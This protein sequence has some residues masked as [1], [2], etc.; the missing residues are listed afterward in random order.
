[1]KVLQMLRTGVDLLKS[2]PY[3]VNTC[4]T[5]NAETEAMPGTIGHMVINTYNPKY[6]RRSLL[7]K[8]GYLEG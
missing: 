1:M 4:S 2:K 3:L 7:I 5:E 8:S 6:R